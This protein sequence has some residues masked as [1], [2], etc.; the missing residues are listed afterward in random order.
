MFIN[1]KRLEETRK[2]LNSILT[3]KKDLGKER[4]EGRALQIREHMYVGK[5]KIYSADLEFTNYQ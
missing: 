4:K 2:K 3:V 1:W 5:H